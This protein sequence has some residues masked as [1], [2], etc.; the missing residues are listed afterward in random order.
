MKRISKFRLLFLSLFFVS[1]LGCEKPIKYAEVEG[2]VKYNGK[3]VPKVKVQF[4]PDAEKGAIGPHSTAI[5]DE[6]GK[7]KLECIDP[8]TKKKKGAVVGL[9]RVLIED[10]DRPFTPQGQKP[11][12]PRI[13]IKYATAVGSKLEIEVKDGSQTIPIDLQD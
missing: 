6:Q 4:L 2:I 9:H 12:P 1:C 13:P 7:F 11:P 3:P 8:Q 10:S 5:T